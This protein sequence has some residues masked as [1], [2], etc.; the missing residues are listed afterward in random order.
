MA[1]T[2]SS[3]DQNPL[4]ARWSSGLSLPTHQLVGPLSC[5]RTLRRPRD[6][7]FSTDRTPFL[8]SSPACSLVS[9]H[10]SCV[11]TSWPP[12]PDSDHQLNNPLAHSLVLTASCRHSPPCVPGLQRD[13]RYRSPV[14][15]F[16]GSLARRRALLFALHTRHASLCVDIKVVSTGIKPYANAPAS[17]THSYA[18][19]A[20][21]FCVGRALLSASQTPSFR[22]GSLLALTV[23]RAG[24][25]SVAFAHIL[26]PA[27]YMPTVCS[28]CTL[29]SQPPVRGPGKFAAPSIWASS[30]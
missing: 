7:R 21:S 23:L 8:V 20:F 1:I 22:E 10:A 14:C 16:T 2:P 6:L 13:E 11:G 15:Q 25:P 30:L 18:M 5:R 9:T 4:I 29:G 12:V 19:G 26:T 28:M 24:K 17:L 27:M 3:P